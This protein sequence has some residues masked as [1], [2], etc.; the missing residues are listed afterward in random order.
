MV[1]QHTLGWASGLVV[2]DVML[3]QKIQML[4]IEHHMWGRLGAGMATAGGGRGGYRWHWQGWP[5]MGKKAPRE[6]SDLHPSAFCWLDYLP[7]LATPALGMPSHPC[8]PHPCPQPCQP[9]ATPAPSHPRQL[10]SAEVQ[11]SSA[12]HVYAYGKQCQRL[13]QSIL[14]CGFLSLTSR[15]SSSLPSPAALC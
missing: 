12:M 13:E 1:L 3:Y 9:R 10:M 7:P 14:C 5:A 2:D 6:T 15:L 8:R 11:S 4:Q